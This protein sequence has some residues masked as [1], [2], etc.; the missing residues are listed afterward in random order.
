MNKSEGQF[1]MVHRFLLF[2]I[3]GLVLGT[4][5]IAQDHDIILVNGHLI[6]A[7][8][9][10]NQPMDIAIRD[11]KV[12][13]IAEKILHKE[14]KR[15]IDVQGL[16]ISPGLIDPHTHVY[17]GEKPRTFAGGSSSVSPDDFTFRSGVTTVVDAGTSGWRNFEDFK[18][19]VIDVSQ[20]RILA[21]LNIAGGGMQGN[22]AQ[23]DI[24]DMNP[25][26]TA[27]TIAKHPQHLVGVKIGHY[28]GKDWTPF[29]RALNA[30]SLANVPLLVECHLPEYSLADQLKR[31]RPGDILSH[32]Y[33]NIR[34]REPIIDS[35]GKLLPEV[36][37][38]KDRGIL[39]D[40]SHGG[41]GF[42][43]NQAIPAIQQGLTPD[44][45]GTDLHRF[46]MNSGMKNFSNVLSKFMAMGM[47]LEAVLTQASWKTA[48]ALKREDLGHLSVGTEA[49]IAI[50]RIRKGEFGFVDSAGQHIQGN[51][52]LEAELTIRAGRIVYDLNG[53]S[54]SPYNNH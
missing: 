35:Q 16:I 23:E 43:F 39:F 45:F 29:D 15:V 4:P 51:Q 11:G 14:G 48:Q 38:A 22:P 8:N 20:T 2:L 17:V 30:G 26:I 37:A 27:Q 12:S 53:L 40:V 52:L 10:I 54:A 21:F 32:T 31:M 3:L 9:G 46:S 7:K 18:K 47:S 42:W 5:L 50:F 36:K 49:D 25:E 28:E 19:T 13:K 24:T 34:D 6:D 44:T 1:H 41:A 33:E